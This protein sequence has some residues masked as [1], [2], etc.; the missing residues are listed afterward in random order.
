M[1][2]AG[3][4]IAFGASVSLTAHA[5]EGYRFAKWSDGS[6]N[7]PRMFT[8]IADR[9]LT[10]RFDNLGSDTLHYDNG[11]YQST[12][13]GEEGTHWGIRI[14]PADLVGHTTLSSVKFYNV[15]SGNYTL[16][17]YQGE[18][19]SSNHMVSSIDFYQSRQTRYRWVEKVLDNAVELDHSKPL[20][21]MLNYEIGDAPA[22]AT[23]WCGNDDGGWYSSNGLTWY[24]LSSQGINATWMIRA[25]LPVDH[26]EYTLTV[27][28]NNRRWGTATGGG[29]YRYGQ[30]ATLIATPSE[31]YH[32][33]R[34]NDGNTDNP[35]TYY[36]KGDTI[37]RAIFAEGEVGISDDMPESVIFY[38]EGRSL[39]V[40]GADGHNLSVYDVMGRCVYHADNYQAM[41]I[42]LPAAG[43]YVVRFDSKSLR[44]VIVQ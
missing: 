17:I 28:T 41:S 20:W 15:R 23:A 27:S 30:S 37:I 2:G 10:A 6:V 39:F 26:N 24:P 43:V 42:K 31:G 16:K 38:V 22:T 33:E 9:T 13:G 5:N 18:R 1:E 35:R 3:D 32:F 14:A 36:V 40:R 19:P 25:Y 44:K 11:K 29:L 34:W 4:D 7:N 8:I 21:V 12:Y